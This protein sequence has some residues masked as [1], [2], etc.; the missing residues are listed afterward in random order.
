MS[1]IYEDTKRR[2]LR[3]GRE[4][5]ISEG[6]NRNRIDSVR[7]LVSKLGIS[8]DEAMDIL[9]I[10]LDERGRLRSEVVPKGQ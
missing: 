9:E 2:Y 6:I 8:V 4:E 1:F 3:E 7:N 5:G 10:P